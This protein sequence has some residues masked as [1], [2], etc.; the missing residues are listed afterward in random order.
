MPLIE[1]IQER[2]AELESLRQAILPGAEE[3]WA[4][5]RYCGLP[6]SREDRAQLESDMLETMLLAFWY[7]GDGPRTKERVFEAVTQANIKLGRELYGDEVTLDELQARDRLAVQV[8]EDM[9]AG[10]PAEESAA[11]RAIAQAAARRPRLKKQTDAMT[12][13][14]AG[15]IR[16]DSNVEAQA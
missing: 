4:V 13:Y 9:R 15:T 14:L 12:A 8:R 3:A 11:A 2:Q 1:R 10:V 16:P 5:A 7:L 6:A